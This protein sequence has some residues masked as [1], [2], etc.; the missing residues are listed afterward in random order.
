MDYDAVFKEIGNFGKWQQLNFFVGS[1]CIVGA[2]FM[3]FMFTFIGFI[4]DFR[5]YIPECEGDLTDLSYDANFT[6]FAIPGNGDDDDITGPHHCKQYIFQNVTNHFLTWNRLNIDP[7]TCSKENFNHTITQVCHQ[8]VYD[9]SKY[10][11][12]ITAELDLSPCEFSSDYWNLEVRNYMVIIYFS[13]T[14]LTRS[15]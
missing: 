6:Q 11:Y 15:I 3:C 9:K 14:T 13:S 4:P 10:E 8:H 2:S 5:C 7:D 1:L 12:P